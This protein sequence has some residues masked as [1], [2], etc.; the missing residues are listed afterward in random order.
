MLR[1]SRME[2]NWEMVTRSE[3]ASE[4]PQILNRNWSLAPN[5]ARDLEAELRTCHPST[6]EHKYCSVCSIYVPVYLGHSL[7]CYCFLQSPLQPWQI[8]ITF[9]IGNPFRNECPVTPVD[10]RWQLLL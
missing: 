1:F 8:A 3:F 4:A 2:G 5:P 6:L 7:A 9:D 10:R